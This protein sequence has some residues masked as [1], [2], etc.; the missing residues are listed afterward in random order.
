DYKLF[1]TADLICTLAL[2]K[3]KLERGKKFTNSEEI[4]FGSAGKLRKTFLKYF[5][6]IELGNN[7]KLQR[8][9]HH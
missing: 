3:T 2:I 7:I 5:E 8:V 1:Q 6:K 4:F 9:I